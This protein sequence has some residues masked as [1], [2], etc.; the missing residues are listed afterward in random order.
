MTLRRKPLLPL[1]RDFRRWLG[2]PLSLEQTL[3]IYAL[4]NQRRTRHR[5]RVFVDDEPFLSTPVISLPELMARYLCWINTRVLPGRN[6]IVLAP[7]R[8]VAERYS[9]LTGPHAIFSRFSGV[10]N[11]RGRTFH[12]LLILDGDALR[13]SLRTGANFNRVF[14]VL[15]PVLTVGSDS[16]AIVVGRSRRHPRRP[17]AGAVRAAHPMVTRRGSE[18]IVFDPGSRL[19]AGSVWIE[20]RHGSPPLIRGVAPPLLMLPPLLPRGGP[21]IRFYVRDEYAGAAPAA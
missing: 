11:M 7:Q 10:D 19:E 12:S 9:R 15:I 14:R 8:L 21:I 4:E 20:K 18:W 5:I 2:L 6:T 3:L 16:I 1:A 13:L 17:F